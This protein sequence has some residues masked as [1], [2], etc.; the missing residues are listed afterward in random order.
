MDMEMEM[1]MEMGTSKDVS[2]EEKKTDGIEWTYVLMLV[3]VESFG[4]PFQYHPKTIGWYVTANQ[5]E[6]TT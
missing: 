4:Y 1:E 3:L 5:G 6:S 2:N